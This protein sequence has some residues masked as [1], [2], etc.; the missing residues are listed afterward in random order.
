MWKRIKIANPNLLT[1]SEILACL[2]QNHSAPARHVLAAMIAAPLHN[3]ERSGVPHTEAL[4]RLSAE[5]SLAA[6]GSVQT[7][8]ADDDVV[9]RAKVGPLI[10]AGSDDDLSI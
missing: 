4:R 9:L 5:E 3:S 7:H 2:P 6:G 8:V 10:R 1:S